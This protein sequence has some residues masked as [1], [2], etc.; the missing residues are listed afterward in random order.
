MRACVRACVCVCVFVCVCVC[1]CVCVWVCG[2]VLVCLSLRALWALPVVVRK[3][4]GQFNV[5]P[6]TER[7]RARAG[8]H[9]ALNTWQTG[10]VCTE[11]TSTL[12]VCC[13][14]E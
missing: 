10:D 1:V 14:H 8:K 6:G 2:C 9:L 7:D 3:E 13:V 11:V 12:P 5:V 4:H